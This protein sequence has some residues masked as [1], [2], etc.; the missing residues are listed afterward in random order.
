MIGAIAGDV[1]GSAYEGSGMKSKEFPLFHALCQFTDDTVLT[2]AVASKLLR[3]VSYVDVFHEFFHSY[4]M[5]G[6]GRSFIRW[7]RSASRLPYGSF[8][9]GSAMR[10]SSI[11]FAFDTLEEVVSQAKESAEVT[12]NHPDGIRGSQAVASAV[13]LAR[14]G[15]S[16]EDIRKH[17]ESEFGYS[18]S[19]RLDDIR[20]SYQFCVSCEGSVPQSI[21]AFLESE[22]YEDAVRNAVSL[23]GDA[24]T[25]AC[26]AGGVAEAFYGQI[27]ADISAKVL[28][29]LDPRLRDIV[30]EFYEKYGGR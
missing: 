17:V 30:T 12:H 18:L 4:P 25:M 20:D 16:K 23:G 8:G 10:V 14:K 24:D 13:F 21:I 5:A 11:G 19:Y 22:N 2:L 26:M 9:N 27:P 15:K 3:G 6:Y 7:A 29:M 28:G 1:I